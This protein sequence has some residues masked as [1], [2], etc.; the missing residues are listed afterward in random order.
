M[1]NQIGKTKIIVISIVAVILSTIIAI[2]AHAILPAEV[3][4]EEF[5][6]IFVKTLG[7]PVVASLY[8]LILFI[9]CTITVNYFGKKSSM[10]GNQIGLRY[11]LS[12]AL[13][14]LI[15]MQEIVVDASPFSVWGI[16][17]VKYQIFM[18]LGDAIP[19][20]IL[21]MII[22]H[23]AVKNILKNTPTH[24][25]NLLNN[26]VTIC[27]ITLAIF[28]IRITGYK[29]GIIYSN[30]NE[31][32]LP[33]SIWTILFGATLGFIFVFLK[34]VYMNMKLYNLKIIILTIG[35]NWII[36]NSF[37]GLI[38]KGVM[39]QMITRS[40]IDISVLYVIAIILERIYLKK[41]LKS[42]NP[43]T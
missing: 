27:F 42:G 30:Y 29:T 5:D 14:Y 24:R 35:V 23:F 16:D 8:F 15:G 22:G 41:D 1:Q 9:H 33:C 38:F 28:I 2:I 20:F 13:I 36:F 43:K 18:G 10:S 34:P 6:S 25:N 39:P 7:F 4:I 3:N 12:F 32:P 31:Y 11:G 17:F 19:V 26:I 21:C 37:I 40:V